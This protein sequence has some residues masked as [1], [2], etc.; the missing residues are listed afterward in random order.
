[1]Q[2]GRTWLICTAILFLS[3][4]VLGRVIHVPADS[5][6]IQGGVNGALPGDTVLV[7]PGMY[8]EHVVL[9]K[10]ILLAGEDMNTTII[11]GELDGTGI[12][13]TAPNAR[14]KSFTI[15]YWRPMGDSR[16]SCSEMLGGVHGHR[17]L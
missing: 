4:P 14:V 5:S 17:G 15:Q 2:K 8:Y 9:D 7:A 3:Q 11:D 16:E 10:A 6:T 12:T 1:M 13:V